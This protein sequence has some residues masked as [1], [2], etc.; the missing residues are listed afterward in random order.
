MDKP[1]II[2]AEVLRRIL[3]PAVSRGELVIA[4]PFGQKRARAAASAVDA[5]GG[6][7]GDAEL[8]AHLGPG[9]FEAS[10][11]AVMHKLRRMT[12]ADIAAVGPRLDAGVVELG[13]LF[14]DLVA[15]FHPHLNGPFTSARPRKLLE[16]TAKALSAVPPPLTVRGAVLRHAWLGDL[17]RFELTRTEVKWWTGSDSF[18]GQ[19]P[20]PRLLAWPEIRQVRRDDRVIE[21]VRLP[22]LFP[23]RK[24]LATLAEPFARAM[25]AFFAASPITDLVNAGRMSPPFVW[26]P[27]LEALVHTSAGAR[28]ARRAI[29]FGEEKGKFALEAIGN[30]G[31]SASRVLA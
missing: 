14:H 5:E 7:T 9:T 26:T 3:V 11:D 4:R 31:G 10:D 20:P 28:V 25:S 13:A 17:P 16:A 15:S 21:L 18:V 29:A 27:T 23:D 22:E 2:L 30:I 12:S 8:R 1:S 24:N 19:K 6:T